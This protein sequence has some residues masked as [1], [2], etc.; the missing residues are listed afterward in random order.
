MAEPQ[1]QLTSKTLFV[2]GCHDA[3]ARCMPQ[4]NN[5]VYLQVVT[6][7]L[8][9]SIHTSIDGQHL[10]GDISVHEHFT[11]VLLDQHVRGHPG[12]SATDEKVLGMLATR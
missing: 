11:C 8:D 4:H 2:Y 6:C 3:S 5:M 10:V 9:Y 12:I 7:V 1:I